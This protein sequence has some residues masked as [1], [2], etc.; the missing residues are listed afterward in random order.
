[1]SAWQMYLEPWLEEAV[2]SGVL[3]TLEAWQLQDEILV[4]QES[5]VLFPK[6][7][8]HLAQRVHLFEA[9]PKSDLVH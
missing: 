6:Q 1:M 8:R 9:Q 7:L 5:F 2:M 4:S 3:S